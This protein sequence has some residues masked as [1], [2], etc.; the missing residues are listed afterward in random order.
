L[1][2][3]ATQYPRGRICRRPLP[4]VYED[5]LKKAISFWNNALPH[6]AEIQ[7]SESLG[8]DMVINLADRFPGR[9]DDLLGLKFGNS[10]V[11]FSDKRRIGVG[12]SEQ[13]MSPDIVLNLMI[14]ELGHLRHLKHLDLPVLR[15]AADN[16]GCYPPM[17]TLSFISE[18]VKRGDIPKL[19][20]CG[21]VDPISS[22]LMSIV[23]RLEYQRLN[24]SMPR[25]ASSTYNA[26]SRSIQLL[27]SDQVIP[28]SV[29]PVVVSSVVKAI[30]TELDNHDL[31]ESVPPIFKRA[32]PEI[33]LIGLMAGLMSPKA[34][35][36]QLFGSAV[37]VSLPFEYPCRHVASDTVARRIV[38]SMPLSLLYALISNVIYA[39]ASNDCSEKALASKS[40]DYGVQMAVSLLT[41]LVTSGLAYLM[42]HIYDRLYRREEVLP[43]AVED[44]RPRVAPELSSPRFLVF[45]N[46]TY[47]GPDP[48]G[49]Q[50]QVYDNP[51]YRSDSEYGTTV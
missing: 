17:A 50:R 48:L 12:V 14:H 31:I 4:K 43:R 9:G 6:A 20:I 15:W 5:A 27:N 42:F 33:V 30:V 7:F 18:A 11:L 32:I 45:D 10:A 1:V 23:T 3:N 19:P 46:P 13:L 36:Y 40:V 35:I 2:A 16:Q 34:A 39:A 51:F 44:V 41:T 24:A 21:S 25:I 26:P 37:S 28:S 47:V 8:A 22:A 38:S 29:I 49:S